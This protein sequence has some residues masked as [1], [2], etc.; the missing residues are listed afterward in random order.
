MEKF[1][2]PAKTYEIIKTCLS[3]FQ[4]I[5][6][7]KIFG[8]RAKGNCKPYSDIDLVLYGTD[9]TEKLTLHI[10]SELEELPTPYKYDIVNY[11][12]LT[13]EPLKKSIDLTAVE[14]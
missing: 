12:N 5:E 2:L 1:G 11:N 3:T 9:I 14:F 6:S 7:V 13:D 8:S 4:E 10:K